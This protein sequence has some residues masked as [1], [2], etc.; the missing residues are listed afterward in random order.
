M[1]PTN[2]DA[3]R[4]ASMQDIPLSALE[5][6]LQDVLARNTPRFDA[7]YGTR[8]DD[9][10]LVMHFYP[11]GYALD[12][13]TDWPSWHKFRDALEETILK[14]FNEGTYQAGYVDELKSFFVIVKP[15]PQVPDLV[16]LL[17]RFFIHLEVV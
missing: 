7:E 2:E 3:L 10:A 5:E 14:Y 1:P 9:D 17:E 16:S 12:S 6:S 4:S 15:K 8:V 11:P 13:N